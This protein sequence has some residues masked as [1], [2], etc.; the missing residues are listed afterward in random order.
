MIRA[1][2]HIHRVMQTQG[3]HT[4]SSQHQVVN[5][6]DVQNNHQDENALDNNTVLVPMLPLPDEDELDA[7]LLGYHGDNEDSMDQSLE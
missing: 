1:L 6:Q 7:L 5:Y 3:N 4:Q 2:E